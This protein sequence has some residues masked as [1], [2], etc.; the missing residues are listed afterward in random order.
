MIIRIILALSL[1]ISANAMIQEI[2]VPPNLLECFQHYAS[3]TSAA[4]TVGQSIHWM[5]THLFVWRESGV[6]GWLMFNMTHEARI[7]YHSL[8]PVINK[9]FTVKKRSARMSRGYRI[10]KEIRMMTN[11][12]RDDFFRA[13]QLLK[14]DTSV[15]PN[16]YSALAAL[17]EG[18]A[19]DSAH[20]GPNFLGWH[21]YFL[22]MFENA[23]REKVPDVSIPY[24]DSSLDEPMANPRQSCLWSE[25]FFGNGD[26]IVTVG[27]FADWNTAVGPLIRNMGHFGELFS[28]TNIANIMSRTY[29]A[30]ITEPLG[31]P[32][33]NIE[34]QHGE[35]HNWVDGQLGELSTAAHD[36]VFYLHHAFVDYLWEQFRR[37]QRMRG[38]NPDLDYPSI[39]NHTLHAAS[40]PLGFGNLQNIDSYSDYLISGM[41][42]YMPSPTCTFEN[43]SCGS[44]FLKC[45]AN[46]TS[47][48]CVSVD[49]SD[50]GMSSSNIR[51]QQAMMQNRGNTQQRRWKRQTPVFSKNPWESIN[52]ANN[53]NSGAMFQRSFQSSVNMM[54]Q[55]SPGI[56][57]KMMQQQPQSPSAILSAS[58]RQM[59]APMRT[60]QNPVGAVQ[61][62]IQNFVASNRRMIEQS[63]APNPLR[64]FSSM[65]QETTCPAIPVNQ[66]YQNS[67]NI[68]G[69]SDVNQW[70]YLPV[71]IIYK[72]PP[73]Y[74]Y[75]SYPII[76]GALSITNDIYS[77]MGYTNL[78]QRLKTIQLATYSSCK[79]STS[80]AGMVYVQ[81]NGLNYLGTYKEFAIVD[82][83]MALSLSTTFIAV[84]SPE[85]GV[86]D[87]L[88]SAFDSCGRICT[89]YCRNPTSPTGESHPCSGAVR[90]SSNYPKLYS[91]NYGDAVLTTWNMA[92]GNCPKLVE[93]QVFVSFYCDYGQEWPLP[94]NMPIQPT[95]MQMQPQPQPN[96]RGFMHFLP[97]VPPN[98]G[99]VPMVPTH[100][101]T[102]V[103]IATNVACDVGY[104]C[105]IGAP[106]K[107]CQHGIAIKCH[108]TCS[109]YAQCGMGTFSFKRCVDGGKFD[110]ATST[111]VT[112]TCAEDEMPP[113]YTGY[114]M[115]GAK[116]VTKRTEVGGD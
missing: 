100:E 43:P 62:N 3:K 86:T 6:K 73:N 47:S 12:E 106:C 5:C 107:P 88:L 82:N 9:G 31:L 34:V 68:N 63:M 61:Q 51:Q 45:A 75:N 84:K 10:R 79:S 59:M 111:C 55:T 57:Q 40:A 32:E 48:Y 80:G 71:K 93:D 58:G 39:V 113:N 112:G 15:Q 105:I 16:K 92:T 52:N 19:V 26:G 56:M 8:L 13:I 33:Y 95:P 67:F 35:V 7:W 27:P 81:S 29:V 1:V 44:P 91:K 94:G 64:G 108:G 101:A 22:L 114:R 20:G 99:M 36:P 14:A 83:R 21:R 30:E 54:G 104:G 50:L 76:N 42:E 23:L 116:T 2:S 65:Q 24:W 41:Y 49:R 115:S 18:L 96:N 11:R 98:T 66:R 97:T 77:S 28:K 46:F 70:V 102:A 85:L 74:N 72:R 25:H 90:I 38:I 4:K 69:L 103:I 109:L 37:Q 17:H 87:V 89:P 60:Q 110:A 53:F 78:H